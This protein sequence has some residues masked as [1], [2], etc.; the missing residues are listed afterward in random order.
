MIVVVNHKLP[1]KG[2]PGLG[3][4]H[5]ERRTSFSVIEATNSGER[6]GGKKHEK[7]TKNP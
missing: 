3:D 1:Q 7:K 5:H 6:M 2:R 4:P